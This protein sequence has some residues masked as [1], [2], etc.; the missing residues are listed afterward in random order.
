MPKSKQRKRDKVFNVISNAIDYLQSSWIN[1]SKVLLC[2]ALTLFVY[3]MI[4]IWMPTVEKIV[5]KI[6]YY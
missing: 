5:F 6:I 3:Y 1:V 4:F 2:F